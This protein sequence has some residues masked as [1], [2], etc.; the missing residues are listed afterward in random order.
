MDKLTTNELLSKGFTI[1]NGKWNYNGKLCVLD[2]Y[3]DWCR[4]CKAQE[5]ILN[6]LSKN[7][8]NVEFYKINVEEEYELAEY[9]SIKSVPTI[10]ICGKETKQFFGLTQKQKIEEILKNQIEILV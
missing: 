6:E 5:M 1:I 4:P 7:Y 2:F 3:T 9:F 8:N 10:I